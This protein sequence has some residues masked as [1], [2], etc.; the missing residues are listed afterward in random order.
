[1]KRIIFISGLLLVLISNAFSQSKIKAARSIVVIIEDY[2]HED[3]N[4][5]LSMKQENG[6]Y[7]RNLEFKYAKDSSLVINREV[8]DLFLKNKKGYNYFNTKYKGKKAKVSFVA[9]E[10]KIQDEVI[11]GTVTSYIITKINCLD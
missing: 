7:A 11:S 5:H 9:E 6:D 2:T 3:G 1:M 4:W 8:K 10:N